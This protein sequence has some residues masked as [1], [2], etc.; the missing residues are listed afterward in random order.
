M[1]DRYTQAAATD[2]AIWA[3]ERAALLAFHAGDRR[4]AE[5]WRSNADKL[6]SK[7]RTEHGEHYLAVLESDA[8]AKGR[9]D[10]KMHTATMQDSAFLNLVSRL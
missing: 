9:H 2:E 6:E 1:S 5:Y 7:F 3:C 10:A 4:K 8:Y